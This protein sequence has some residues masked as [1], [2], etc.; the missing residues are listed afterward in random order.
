VRRA[1]MFD[2]IFVY[3]KKEKADG[4]KAF[5]KERMKNY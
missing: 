5:K 3:N 4:G 2:M 1:K